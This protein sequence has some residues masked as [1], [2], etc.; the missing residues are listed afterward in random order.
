MNNFFLSFFSF[1]FF[2]LKKIKIK[3]KIKKKK[4]KPSGDGRSRYPVSLF[5]S[6]LVMTFTIR[7]VLALAIQFSS[8]ETRDHDIT[9]G[10][11]VDIYRNVRW[12][13]KRNGYSTI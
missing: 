7:V 13:R 4:T 8:E 6:R 5:T 2:F 12:C 1:L 3:I 9:R 10:D 11:V